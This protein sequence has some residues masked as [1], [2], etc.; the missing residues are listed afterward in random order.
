MEHED[1]IFFILDKARHLRSDHRQ[2]SL[3]LSVESAASLLRMPRII[4]AIETENKKDQGPPHAVAAA[5]LFASEDYCAATGIIRT[6]ERRELLFP[7]AQMATVAKAYGLQAID[8]VCI[9]FKDVTNLQEEAL[10]GRHLGYDGKQAIHP[11]QV[12]DIQRAYSPSEKGEL[13]SALPCAFTSS[14]SL[15]QA[16][17]PSPSSSITRYSQGGSDQGCIRKIGSRQQRC[18]GAQGGRG[19]YH[20]R[21]AHAQASRR[22]LDKGT[23]WQLA[24]SR[25]I[26]GVCLLMNQNNRGSSPRKAATG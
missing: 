1:D 18:R 24:D 19:H 8:M 16:H 4:E 2:L 3:V 13:S 6:K 22:H 5:L 12:T 10:E 7:R 26:T 14:L 23:R 15:F 17:E 20:D 21:R 25:C 9:D 11:A